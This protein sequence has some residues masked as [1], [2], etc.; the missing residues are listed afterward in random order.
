M[1]QKTKEAITTLGWLVLICMA[2][3]FTLVITRI[4]GY[5]KDL[6]ESKKICIYEAAGSTEYVVLAPA[7]DMKDYTI[8]SMEDGQRKVTIILKE[9]KGEE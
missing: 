9:K 7:Y 3:F 1:K 2:V 8:E 4:T 6:E 5:N